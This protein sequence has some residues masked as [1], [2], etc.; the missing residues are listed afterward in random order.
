MRCFNNLGFFSFWLTTFWKNPL[1]KDFSE[2]FAENAI[3]KGIYA[4]RKYFQVDL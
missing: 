1:E 2:F 3:N 4:G